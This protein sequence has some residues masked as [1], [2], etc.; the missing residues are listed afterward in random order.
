MLEFTLA[1]LPLLAM[2]TVLIDVAWGIYAKATLA[3]AVRAGLRVGI[4]TTGEQALTAG[5]GGT[6]SDLTTMV[7]KAV[8]SNALG[9]L[10]GA[11]GLAKIQVHYF[12][13]PAVNST[14]PLTDVSG[15][16]PGGN[17]PL[18]IMQVSVEGFSL[19]PLIPRFFGWRQA[20]DNADSNI[21]VVAADLIEP[22]RDVPPIGL[23]P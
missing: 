20:P 23:A 10:P 12:Q 6:A 17:S 21:N 16:R 1:F 18:N 4:T 13:P 7:K 22:S 14:S 11:S 19:H 3:S 8:Q 5:P 15:V 9:L 2:T